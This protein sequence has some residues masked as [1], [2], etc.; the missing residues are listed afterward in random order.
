MRSEVKRTVY[1]MDWPGRPRRDRAAAHLVAGSGK[2][3]EGRAK[4]KPEVRVIQ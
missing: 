3:G 2:T 4:L 1:G